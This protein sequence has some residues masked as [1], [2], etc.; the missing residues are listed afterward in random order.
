MTPDGRI[1]FTGNADKPLL[2]QVPDSARPPKPLRLH[3][4]FQSGSC[5]VLV[6]ILP[7]E[8]P[9][10]VASYIYFQIGPQVRRA[11][12]EIIERCLPACRTGRNLGYTDI[13]VDTATVPTGSSTIFYVWV[14]GARPRELEPLRSLRGPWE[15]S[16]YQA[17]A[18]GKA[19]RVEPNLAAHRPGLF[20]L[21]NW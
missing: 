12:Q 5:E 4:S 10:K 6:K 18:S 20:F 17:N 3:A 9:T 15:P 11:A 16:F 8:R 7:A 1:E 2:L 14:Q 21:D 19:V 13:R